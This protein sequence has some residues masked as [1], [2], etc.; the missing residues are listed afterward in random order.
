VRMTAR[1]VRYNGRVQ[2]VGFRAT[3]VAVAGAYAVTGWVRN[4][5]DGRV[6]LLA[7]GAESEVLRF[8]QAVRDHWGGFIR[9][10]QIEAREP[11]GRHSR[12]DVTR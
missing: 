8:L 9:D 10:E 11:T 4:L 1:L 5:A 7:E 2:G 3:A 12:F 6:E